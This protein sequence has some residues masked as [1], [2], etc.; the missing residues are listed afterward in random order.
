MTSFFGKGFKVI[1]LKGIFS[2]EKTEEIIKAK[3]ITAIAATTA[4]VVV[5]GVVCGILASGS[6]KVPTAEETFST[7][8]VSEDTT[9]TDTTAEETSVSEESVTTT[10]SLTTLKKTTAYTKEFVITGKTSSNPYLSAI[11]KAQTYETGDISKER[12]TVRNIDTGKLVT[13]DGFDILCQVVN[14]EMG[15][16]FSTEALKAQAVAAYTT[17]LYCE[18]TDQIPELGLNANYSSKIENAV[19][20]V[21]GLV[22]TYNGKIANTVF[23]A[24]SAGIT[25]SSKNAWGGSLPY[26]L[27]VTSKYDSLASDYKEEKSLS[28]TLVQMNLA[29][30]YGIKLSDDPEDWFKITETYDGSYVKTVEFCDGTEVTGNFIKSLFGLKS[31]AFI[32]S[33]KE[34][35]F[36]FTTYGYGHGVGMSQQGANYYAVKDGLKFDQILKHYYTGVK[37]EL[38]KNAKKQETTVKTTSV[39]DK[40]TTAK[41]TTAK[42]VNSGTASK[43]TTT[44][45]RIT[46]KTTTTT[47][48]QN[49]DYIEPD[50]TTAPPI[51]GETTEPI[52]TDPAIQD[53]D[54][55]AP[56]EETDPVEPTNPV[57]N[58]ENEFFE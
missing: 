3:R 13:S 51:E 40:T 55:T 42:D 22:C 7:D 14:G 47:T 8:I 21:E 45:K 25:A 32:I 6:Q 16:S 43:R 30:R 20:S 50:I 19:K 56:P 33:Y 34:G 39:K 49:T 48:E 4:A 27:S 12:H 17:I 11:A 26:L 1:K 44:W 53:P 41:T 9:E 24:S 15:S 36:T 54:P 37:V 2:K 46:R 23:S 29:L 31:N 18:S 52:V 28:Q 5:L 58:E 57:E 10:A 38:A 35:K